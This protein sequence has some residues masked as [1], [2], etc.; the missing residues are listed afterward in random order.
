MPNSA[1]VYKGDFDPFGS[2]NPNERGNSETLLSS[3]QNMHIRGNQ[4]GP[5]SHSVFNTFDAEEFSQ[6]SQSQNR[7]YS[8][9]DVQPVHNSRPKLYSRFGFALNEEDDF[10]STQS[11]IPSV[12][13]RSLQ[14]SGL[15]D[16]FQRSS[17]NYTPDQNNLRG[18][19]PVGNSLGLQSEEISQRAGL[20]RVDRMGLPMVSQEWR[21]DLPHTENSQHPLPFTTQTPMSFSNRLPAR[22]MPPGMAPPPGYSSGYNERMS[23]LMNGHHFEDRSDVNFHP[24]TENASGHQLSPT[25]L[26]YRNPNQP[27]WQEPQSRSTMDMFDHNLRRFPDSQPP[28]LGQ[29][30]S[31]LASEQSHFFGN[32]HRPIAEKRSTTSSIRENGYFRDSAIRTSHATSP[33]NS[34]DYSDMMPSRNWNGNMNN[35]F[36]NN[37]LHRLRGYDV[38]FKLDSGELGQFKVS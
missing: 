5:D 2:V 21:G 38:D 14:P 33:P 18:M 16:P 8:G 10:D 11:R 34:V 1:S 24:Y 30:D 23:N 3:L 25:H 27:L 7:K 19:Y 36:Q 4:S 26:S 22:N 6:I 35:S 20:R 9:N 12:T 37:P 29:F 13:T 17:P 32:L 31:Q 15:I 28:G